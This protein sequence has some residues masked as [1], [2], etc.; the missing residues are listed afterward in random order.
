MLPEQSCSLSLL[1]IGQCFISMAS[2][3]CHLQTIRANV[4]SPSVHFPARGAMHS[5]D[6]DRKGGSTD[7]GWGEGG[8][9]TLG[10]YIR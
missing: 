10:I 7:G 4:N 1:S 8:G 5:S 6:P 9:P 3:S 2:T